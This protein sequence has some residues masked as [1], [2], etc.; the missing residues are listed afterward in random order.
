M[1]YNAFFS[2]E[3]DTIRKEKRYRVFIELHHLAEQFP[4]ALHKHQQ[5]VITWCSND[6]LAQGHDPTV[7]KAMQDALE[8]YGGGSGGTRNISG[9]TDLHVHLEN[10]LAQLH[11]KEA[12]LLF[13]SGYVAN[14]TTLATLGQSHPDWVFL[15]DAANHASMIHGIRATKAQK[16][17]FRHN[18]TNHLESILQSLKPETPKLIVCESIYSM[19]GDCAPLQD[20]ARLAKRYHALT[21]TDEVH[22]V[23]IYGRNGG[24]GAE[25]QNVMHHIDIIQGTLGKA[26]G[27]MGGYIASNAKIIDVI[28]S[29]APAF[30]F[31]TSLPPAV[32]AGACQ[33]IK[34][35]AQNPQ[36][37]TDMLHKAERLKQKLQD[38]HIPMLP[39]QSHIIPIIIGDAEK[40]TTISQKL[41]AKGHYVQPVNYPTVAR[42]SERLRVTLTPKHDESMLDA[43]VTELT[44]IWHATN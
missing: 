43:F 25:Q 11:G 42:N 33:A 7:I 31:T 21:Y 26:F 13:S 24:G 44:A 8:T 10:Q 17:I 40:C 34:N 36:I 19:D 18:D 39:S 41:L 37:R 32:V 14:E 1:D 6:Y 27:T 16:H 20:I 15:S 28:R 9:T 22:A 35:I 12:A 29:K 5:R 4:Y 2:R 3:L 23:G 38:A 30:I